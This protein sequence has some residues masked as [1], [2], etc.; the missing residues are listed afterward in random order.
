MNWLIWRQHRKQIVFAGI[1]VALYTLALVLSGVHIVHSYQ[2]L[3]DQF[4]LN[5]GGIIRYL[6]H[7][8]IV[9]PLLLGLFWGVPLIGKEYEDGT[10]KLAWTQGITRRR[11]LSAKLGWMMGVAAVYGTVLSA[12]SSYCLRTEYKLGLDQFEWL[13]FDIHGLMPIV[14]AVFAV[15]LGAMIGAWARRVM[16][17]LAVTLGI[18]V[19]LQGAIGLYIRPHYRSP[20]ISRITQSYSTPLVGG[21]GTLLSEKKTGPSMPQNEAI[22]RLGYGFGQEK[23]Y[24]KGDVRVNTLT[25]TQRWQPARLFWPFQFVEAGIYLGLTAVLV[26]ATYW[27]VLKRDA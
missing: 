10:N 18:F 12:A 1:V 2:R 26:A 19:V 15:A 20:Q 16:L 13:H 21:E 25:T 8:T 9:V 14:F 27:L 6:P 23:Y 4:S 11:W 5:D 17:A 24:T 7:A 3:A 22:W